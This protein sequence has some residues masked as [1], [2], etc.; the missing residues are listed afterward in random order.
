MNEV[1]SCVEKLTIILPKYVITL[2]LKTR[3]VSEVSLK[4]SQNSLFKCHNCH[5]L[6]NFWLLISMA[7]LPPTPPP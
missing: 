2:Y 3:A 4:I 1:L 6:S 7:P 5:F